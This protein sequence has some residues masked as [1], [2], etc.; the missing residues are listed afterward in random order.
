MEEDEK[1]RQLLNGQ[2]KASKSFIDTVIL[3][4]PLLKSRNYNEVRNKINNMNRKQNKL[5]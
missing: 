4:D 5:K 1:L 3:T 2:N